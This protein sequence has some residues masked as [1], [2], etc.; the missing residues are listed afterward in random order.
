ME[1]TRNKIGKIFV[2]VIAAIIFLSLA[3][4]A[5]LVIDSLSKITKI[6]VSP[7]FQ[8]GG[9][10]DEGKYKH[11]NSTI[12]SDLFE[13]QGLTVT[14]SFESDFD[15]QVYY[16]YP[17]E[18]FA[19]STEVMSGYYEVENL[20]EDVMYARIVIDPNDK[21]VLY[22]YNI[23]DYSMNIKIEVDKEQNFEL[24]NYLDTTNSVYKFEGYRANLTDRIVNMYESEDYYVYALDYKKFN[25]KPGDKFKI[26]Y[27]DGI[28]NHKETVR[29]VS[30]TFT[31][32]DKSY[33]F[34]F[35][36]SSS[37]YINE[38]GDETITE[39]VFTIP[40]LDEGVSVDYVLITVNKEDSIN[41][42]KAYIKG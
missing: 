35:T 11:T 29:F 15:F 1:K 9:L 21:E 18:E 7:M 42:V 10:D 13:C 23:L 36:Q 31:K 30:G 6:Q 19:S 20:P 12:Y 37:F 25:F 24:R 40:V 3:A 41:L 4:G 8:V 5:T 32:S 2:I 28:A 34:D 27:T 39:V 33:T 38:L 26:V 17:N 22:W 16:Y 14:P